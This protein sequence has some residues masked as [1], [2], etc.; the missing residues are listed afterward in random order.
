MF[1]KNFV[2]KYP[3]ESSAN[4]YGIEI[5]LIFVLIKQFLFLSYIVFLLF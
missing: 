5:V 4:L 3:M 2:W 1:E